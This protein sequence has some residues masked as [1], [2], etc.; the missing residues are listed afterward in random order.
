MPQIGACFGDVPDEPP[1]SSSPSRVSSPAGSSKA[2]DTGVRKMGPKF[3][4]AKPPPRG[5]EHLRAA[6]AMKASE[7]QRM[8]PET[9]STKET[10]SAKGVHPPVD[11]ADNK[12]GCPSE[13]KSSI[14]SDSDDDDSDESWHRERDGAPEKDPENADKRRT[15]RYFRRMAKLKAHKEARLKED[16][17]RASGADTRYT[18]HPH[19]PSVAI[20]AKY[21]P[22]GPDHHMFDGGVSS[23]SPPVQCDICRMCYPLPSATLPVTMAADG[24]LCEVLLQNMAFEELKKE[25]QKVVPDDPEI[26]KNQ[27]LQVISANRFAY[28]EDCYASN[29]EKVGTTGGATDVLYACFRC[30]GKAD[31]G[32]PD[33]Y[34]I[35]REDTVNGTRKAQVSPK[36]LN[37]RRKCLGRSTNEDDLACENIMR[38]ILARHPAKLLPLNTVYKKVCEHPWLRQAA[39]HV[40]K[41]GGGCYV[42]YTCPACREAP[43]NPS[44]WCR[45]AKPGFEDLPDMSS[46]SHGNWFCPNFQ[47]FTKWGGGTGWE[48]RLLIWPR[49]GIVT[50]GGGS[51]NMAYLGKV[52]TEIEN[53]IHVC[54]AASLLSEVYDP[55]TGQFHELPFDAAARVIGK[56]NEQTEDTLAATFPTVR[57]RAVTRQVCTMRGVRPYCE[58]PAVSLHQFGIIYKSI[59]IPQDLQPIDENLRTTIFET[60]I[61]LFNVDVEC[62]RDDLQKAWK[63]ARTIQWRKRNEGFNIVDYVFPAKIQKSDPREEVHDH[64]VCSESM[65]RKPSAWHGG[66]RIK[67]RGHTDFES[68][69]KLRRAAEM[70]ISAQ[71]LAEGH[72]MPTPLAAPPPPP[73]P[74][75]P[76]PPGPPPTVAQCLTTQ[77][78]GSTML[79]RAVQHPDVAQSNYP[80]A[81]VESVSR[82]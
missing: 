78:Y 36:W 18:I 75:V 53:M 14:S 28:A 49:D 56:I 10:G 5:L 2:S 68:D 19:D 64:R 77:F 80:F 35:D 32:N 62:P 15:E 40:A 72:A 82:M 7:T 47:C 67:H 4:K 25:L 31:H 21:A 54:K 46:T 48:Q 29:G 59:L 51:L 74:G 66:G 44:R 45:S 61:M 38:R 27:K 63:Q 17:K 12:A 39:D 41:L 1:L 42:L 55:V 20:D 3:A 13:D 70:A 50:Q 33:Y 6:P 52:S 57:R 9:A 24:K 69:P 60:L 43:A 58:H 76:P 30:V 22:T 8:D 81:N 65:S 79:P 71:T 37:R 26:L 34:I 73:P 11:G 16:R 23:T